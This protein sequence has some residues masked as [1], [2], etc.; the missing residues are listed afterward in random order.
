MAVAEIV[1]TEVLKAAS[2]KI[3]TKVID[4]LALTY[5]RN[6]EN[7]QDISEVLE[8]YLE[9]CYR[10]SNSMSTIV[11]RNQPKTLEELYIPLTISKETFPEKT[12][13]EKY[14][15]AADHIDFLEKY[16]LIKIVDTA[17]MGK[18]TIVKFLAMQAITSGKYIPVVIELRQLTE[19]T[20]LFTYI[21][22][23]MDLPD[24]KFTERNIVDLF[25]CGDFLF[26]F[27]G[28][29]EIP[30]DYTGIVTL[31]MHEFIKSI[32]KNHVVISSRKDNGLDGF[33]SF[34]TFSIQPLC[35]NEAFALI[36]KYD[37]NGERGEKLIQAIE[38]DS[39][40][41]LLREFLINPLMV[42]L[43]YK[44]YSYK[45]DIP[46][47]KYVF[48][49][50]VYA[51]LFEEHDFTKPGAYKRQKRS[52]LDMDEFKTVLKRLGFYCA[53]KNVVEF[54]RE[55]LLG[56]LRDILNKLPNIQTSAGDFQ[57]DLVTTVPLFVQESG[58][59]RWVHKSFYEYFA[60]CFISYDAKERQ[61]EIMRK[62]VHSKL[63]A[64]FHNVLDFCFDMDVSLA[65]KEIL[66]PFL[67]SFIEQYDQAYHSMSAENDIGCEKLK[68]L[69]S[70]SN[71]ARLIIYVMDIDNPIDWKQEL[72]IETMMPLLKMENAERHQRLIVVMEIK[73]GYSVVNLLEMKA[74]DI[75]ANPPQIEYNE[76][77]SGSWNNGKY[78][79]DGIGFDETAV[80]TIISPQDGKIFK[81][82]MDFA[83][84][85]GF[86][87]DREKCCALRKKVQNSI[88]T[89][90]E[91]WEELDL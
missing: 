3:V 22:S 91:Y 35:K 6:K 48:Y 39:N 28:Y 29:D 43:L 82:I 18:S 69:K 41:H 70:L 30:K 83:G 54:T 32:G 56:V 14:I 23:Q 55:E 64:R 79:L 58:K 40:L 17:G 67:D 34:Q 77:I 76:E 12:E 86:I 33:Q 75:F 90:E 4:Y 42:S 52:G 2:T 26:L 19:Q 85:L 36:R 7:L 73:F 80:R 66:L 21:K 88:Q 9:R 63:F 84:E 16:Q 74:I 31:K 8:R 49:D 27:D 57:R 62:L 13:R 81:N 20:D 71:F 72:D 65:Q 38:K 46:Y 60:A 10:N 89:E 45:P 15:L 59:Y 78:V 50:Q 37:N 5:H 61:T 44:A 47:K 87:V 24:E 1:F 11:F 51:A 25:M 68:V 53:L